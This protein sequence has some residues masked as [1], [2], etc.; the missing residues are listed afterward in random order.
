MY[1]SVIEPGVILTPI[2]DKALS[3]SGSALSAELAQRYSAEVALIAKTARRARKHGL[4]PDRVADVIVH[5]LSATRPRHRYVVGRD[6]RIRLALQTIL[7]RRWMD[8]L[9][10]RVVRKYGRPRT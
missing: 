5:A 9:V 10:H 3:K 7:P 8:A 1:A 6:A 2:W 4:P